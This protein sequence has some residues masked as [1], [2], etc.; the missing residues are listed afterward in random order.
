MANPAELLHEVFTQ[1]GSRVKGGAPTGSTRGDNAV[2]DQHRRCVGYLNQIE[3]VLDEMDRAGKRVATYQKQFPVWVKTVFNYG[4]NWG[5]SDAPVSEHALDILDNLIEAM[6]PFVP[7]LDA[8]RF[9]ELKRYLNTVQDILNEDDS[10]APGVRRGAQ[11]LVEN[12]LT[13]VDSYTVVGD[14]E[15]ERALKSLLG[16]L[17]L[18]T[19]QSTKKEKWRDILA[20]FFIPYAV[21]QVPGLEAPPIPRLLE[22]MQG[23]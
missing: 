9:D 6:E 12:I 3:E 19:V 1:W 22:L 15:L 18:V 11:V 20:G 13:L 2:L 14:F 16:S 17:A 10:L 7:T 4:R 23:G 8:E 5:S 21:N